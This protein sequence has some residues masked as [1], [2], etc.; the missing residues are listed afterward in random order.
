MHLVDKI[1]S[2]RLDYDYQVSSTLKSHTSKIKFTNIPLLLNNDT[3]A[4]YEMKMKIEDE[5]K[6][7]QLLLSTTAFTSFC[8]TINLVIYVH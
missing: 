7:E 2:L 5:E 8:V 1:E 3:V 4:T 6:F